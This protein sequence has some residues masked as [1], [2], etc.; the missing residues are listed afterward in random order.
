MRLRPVEQE[1]DVHRCAADLAPAVLAIPWQSVVNCME[2]DRLTTVVSQLVDGVW[3]R[4]RR[5]DEQRSKGP[6]RPVCNCRVVVDGGGTAWTS[7]W[8]LDHVVVDWCHLSCCD[9]GRHLDEVDSENEH[10]WLR[11]VIFQ[12]SITEWLLTLYFLKLYHTV[13]RQ[14]FPQ[15]HRR[16]V[17]S[18]FCNKLCPNTA[19]EDPVCLVQ[20]ATSASRVSVLHWVPRVPPGGGVVLRRCHSELW[21]AVTYCCHHHMSLA[22]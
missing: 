6:A 10:D 7:V 11:Q 15:V 14:I 17:L 21:W 9:E 8:T 19:P 1:D 5:L 2:I 12:R 3:L 20:G 22:P 13:V 18:V 4:C 16:Q